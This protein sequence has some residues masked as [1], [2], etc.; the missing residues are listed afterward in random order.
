M[1]I[2]EISSVHYEAI[3]NQFSR[4]DAIECYCAVADP[5]FPVG[6]GGGAEPLGGRQPPTWVLFGKNVCENERIGSCWG[7]GGGGTCWQRP[8]RPA[9]AVDMT[10]ASAH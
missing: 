7:G 9:N 3:M 5:G 6:G 10:W 4:F 2:L 1:K 8:P